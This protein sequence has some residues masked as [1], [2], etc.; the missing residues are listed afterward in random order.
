[1][2]RMLFHSASLY[3]NF[4]S[5]HQ[6]LEENLQRSEEELRFASSRASEKENQLKIAIQEKQ[7]S[8]GWLLVV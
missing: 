2:I 7:V 8:Y 5:S 6:E 3:N 4:D 1:M